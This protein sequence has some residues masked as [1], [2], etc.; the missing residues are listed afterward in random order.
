MTNFQ[1]ISILSIK[2]EEYLGQILSHNR[3]EQ[4][5]SIKDN[6]LLDQ[7]LQLMAGS[8]KI[9][10][11][12]ENGE[13]IS[14][15]SGKGFQLNLSENFFNDFS[16]CERAF[17]AIRKVFFED[18]VDPD[19][20]LKIQS[21]GP[22][23]QD[24]SP[25]PEKIEN[26][27]DQSEEHFQK[28]SGVDH[29]EAEHAEIDS[30]DLLSKVGALDEN[31]LSGSLDHEEADEFSN[32]VVPESSD[33]GSSSP[34]AEPQ[35]PT[36]TEDTG[37]EEVR[38]DDSENDTSN[39][40][41]D[42]ETIDD[43]LMQSAEEDNGQSSEE[44]ADQII[45]NTKN[46]QNLDEDTQEP[47]DDGDPDQSARELADNLLSEAADIQSSDPDPEETVLDEEDNSDSDQDLINQLL[48]DS[49]EIDA[50]TEADADELANQILQENESTTSEDIDANALA[51][52][53]LR[54][55]SAEVESEIDDELEQ[56]I[57][58]LKELKMPEKKIDTL[59]QAVRKGKASIETVW[60]TVEKLRAN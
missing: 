15:E 47:E 30:E 56:C 39:L 54:A 45:S 53:I 55:D 17:R 49:G 29:P 4:I 12:E 5:E 7:F 42:P 43:L 37:S 21:D 57:Q 11:Y 59:V 1:R 9:I 13:C 28:L 52:E 27:S 38:A 22:E 33:D 51:E 50:D 36:I 10:G 24:I 25:Y 31:T 46:E 41:V 6:K 26:V 34:Q 40:G 16:A 23:A 18:F 35:D 48:Q 14:W 60:E 8:P 2:E 19:T 44:P 3:R 58:Q 32:L 20:L